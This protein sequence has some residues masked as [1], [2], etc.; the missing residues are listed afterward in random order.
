MKLLGQPKHLNSIGDIDVAKSRGKI[1]SR[2]IWAD[3]PKRPT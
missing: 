2:F 1:E 3:N